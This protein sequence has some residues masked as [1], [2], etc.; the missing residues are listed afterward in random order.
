[1]TEQ[2]ALSIPQIV[3]WHL[4]WSFATPSE[5]KQKEEFT[6]CL[7]SGLWTSHLFTAM[8]CCQ[9][10]MS[11]CYWDYLHY[12]LEQKGFW[13]KT[14]NQTTRTQSAFISSPAVS[15]SWE[16]QPPPTGTASATLRPTHHCAATH[17]NTWGPT[18]LREASAPAPPILMFCPD[19]TRQPT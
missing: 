4:M 13:V 6:R 15:S 14:D 2:W 3:F 1:M 8:C 5:S 11:A 17:R 18:W 19:D 9:S 16:A 12:P 10:K 7:I